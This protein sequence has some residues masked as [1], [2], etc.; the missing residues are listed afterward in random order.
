MVV[1]SDRDAQPVHFNGETSSFCN[2]GKRSVVIVAKQ[3]QRRSPPLLTRP[4]LAVRKEQV[5]PAIAIVV[6]E[7][8]PWPQRLGQILFAEGSGVMR[9]G[10]ASGLSDISELN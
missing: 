10:E 5:L 9:E 4:I 8:N 3:L 2:V 1:I 6:D 7:C